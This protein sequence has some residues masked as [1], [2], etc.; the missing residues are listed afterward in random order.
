MTQ[1]YGPKRDLTAMFT[2]MLSETAIS[3]SDSV[4]VKQPVEWLVGAMRALGIRPS[5]LPAADQRQLVVGLQT[6]GQLPFTP[7][8]VGGWPLGEAWL[9]TSSAETRLRLASLLVKGIDLQA[10]PVS[11]APT[12]QR[13][14]ALATALGVTQWTPRTAAALTPLASTPNRLIAFGLCAPEYVVSA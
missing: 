12:A 8:N 14:T 1:A 2:A 4:L 3:A 11:K 13:P 9:T 10:L 6:L 7:P 5:K